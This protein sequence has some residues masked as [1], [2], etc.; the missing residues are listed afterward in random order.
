[1]IDDASYYHIQLADT[2]GESAPTVVLATPNAV[3]FVRDSV[4]LGDLDGDSVPE[5]FEECTSSEGVHYFLFT[6]D[7]QRWHAYYYVPY[8][9]ESNCRDSLFTGEGGS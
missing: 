7:V 3:L 1:M 4:V 5:R 2:T 6:G 9:L 8:D